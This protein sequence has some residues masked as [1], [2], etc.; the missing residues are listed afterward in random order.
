MALHT[1]LVMTGQGPGDHH[2]TRR[3]TVLVAGSLTPVVS[4]TLGPPPATGLAALGL[5]GLLVAVTGQTAGVTALQRVLTGERTGGRHLLSRLTAG[6]GSG[7]TTGEEDSN[8]LRAGD[9][10]VPHIAGHSGG[11]TTLQ[12]QLSPLL[13][14]QTTQRVTGPRAAVE[15]VGAH[16]LTGLSALVSLSGGVAVEGTQVATSQS[17]LTRSSTASKRGEREIHSKC[18]K[19]AGKIQKMC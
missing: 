8:E 1:G 5:V 12:L 6:E 2:I 18:A 9:C 10:V 13:A 3:S 16:L 4:P 17:L 7:V 14:P 11:V 19:Y 15:L